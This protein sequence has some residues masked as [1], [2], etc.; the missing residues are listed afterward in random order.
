M[1]EFDYEFKDIFAGITP[2]EVSS[3]LNV[4]LLECH[5]LEPISK[6]YKLHDFVIDMDTDSYNWGNA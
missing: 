3:K 2:Q 5:N 4:N 1:K 6:D